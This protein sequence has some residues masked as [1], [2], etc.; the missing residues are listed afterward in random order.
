M[1]L[2]LNFIKALVQVVDEEIDWEGEEDA[3]ERVASP[4]FTFRSAPAV[5][6]V[7]ARRNRLNSYWLGINTF[8]IYTCNRSL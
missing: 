4:A 7:T 8:T 2:G 1:K 5:T 6:R 3:P